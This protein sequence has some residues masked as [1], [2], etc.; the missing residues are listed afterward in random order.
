MSRT[1]P[2]VEL[3]ADD[4]KALARYLTTRLNE[5]NYYMSSD[6][7]DL[8]P[9]YRAAVKELGTAQLDWETVWDFSIPL[10]AAMVERYVRAIRALPVCSFNLWG[11]EQERAVGECLAFCDRL[12][13]YA[14]RARLKAKAGAQ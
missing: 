11:A 4:R 7:A 8:Q 10:T 13:E 9:N 3:T 5:L 2:I 6:D 1:S 12:R 14:R